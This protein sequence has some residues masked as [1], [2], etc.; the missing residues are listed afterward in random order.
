MSVSKTLKNR[1][2]VRFRQEPCDSESSAVL[3]E[4]PRLEGLSD[5]LVELDESSSR[6]IEPETVL[7]LEVPKLNYLTETSTVEPQTAKVTDPQK[8]KKFLEH[9]L[10]CESFDGQNELYDDASNLTPKSPKSV[11]NNSFISTTNFLKDN[12]RY[13]SLLNPHR[14]TVYVVRTVNVPGS[15]TIEPCSVTNSHKKPIVSATIDNSPQNNHKKH[16][17][18]KAFTVTVPS[19]KRPLARL[20][21]N[22]R[23]SL[24]EEKMNVYSSGANLYASSSIARLQEKEELQQ[25]NDRFLNYVQRVRQIGDNDQI[26][27][28]SVIKTARALEDEVTHIKSLYEKEL[29]NVRSELDRAV[30]ERNKLQMHCNKNRQAMVDLEDR[31][32]IETD[33]NKKLIEEI[34]LTQQR[35]GQ[36]EAELQKSRASAQTMTDIQK[37]QRDVDSILRENQDLKRRYEKEQIARQ[38]ADEKVHQLSK[39]VEFSEQ[40]HS[41]QSKDLHTRL[42]MATGTILELESRIRDVGKSDTNVSSVL[43]QIREASEL[44]LHKYKLES[45]GNYNRNIASLKAQMDRDTQ[46]I[47]HLTEEKSEA[48]SKIFELQGSL[49]T[50][51]AQLNLLEQQRRAAE[52]MVREEKS[53]SSEQ[54][55]AM[56]RKLKEIQDLL[57]TKMQEANVARDSSVPLKAEIDAM[58]VLLGE[59][60]K[61]LSVTASQQSTY[62]S[63]AMDQQSMLPYTP[64]AGPPPSSATLNYVP[65]TTAP[66][67][68]AAQT[69]SFQQEPNVLPLR[70]SEQNVERSRSVSPLEMVQSPQVDTTQY[71]YEVT[72][73]VNKLQRDYHPHVS[74]PVGPVARVK[75]APVSSQRAVPLVSTS[76]GQGRDYFDEMF[77]DLTRETLYTQVRPKSSPVERPPSS[78]YHDYN[79]ATSSAIGDI[80]IL[81]VQQDGKYIRL[82]NDGKQDVEFGGYLLQQNVGGHPVA[83]YRFPPRTKFSA[84]TTLTV[85]SGSND[86]LLHQPPLDFVWKE[87][88]KWGTGPECTTILCKPNG[89]A[90]AWTTAAHRFTRNAF[91]DTPNQQSTMEQEY[92]AD[93]NSVDFDKDSLTEVT[94]N[95][96]EPRQ[97]TVYLRREKQ[98]PPILT[99]QKHPHGISPG[100]DVHPTA[101]Q[102]RSFTYGNDN[103]SM[104]RQSRS[105][106]TRPDPIPGQPYAGAAGQRMGSGSLKKYPT[107][108]SVPRTNGPNITKAA[109][110]IR[111][112]PPSPFLSPLQQ[113]FQA[114]NNRPNSL[115]E[116]QTSQTPYAFMTPH[117]RFDMGLDQIKSQHNLEFQPPMPRP[118]LFSSW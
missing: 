1:K 16:S 114:F 105:Q 7:S 73:S 32:A 27:S 97:E 92:P 77:K 19:F 42:E 108:S 87:Q 55:H 101:G 60:E 74:R 95:I 83:V 5:L 38:E 46:M 23:K 35:M 64:T 15:T 69:Y 52:E 78:V 21:N 110:T 48:Q 31:I 41:Q 75:S 44:E 2:S 70:E 112:G 58:K 4:V 90:I 89:Q 117:R 91:E 104:N 28:S 61:R 12:K 82:H 33:K 86:P 36:L 94:V 14:K 45:E 13:R 54:I 106:S 50:M 115:G 93:D 51:E 10:E 88:K 68:T 8:D 30:M 111:L 43:K 17:S 20:Q 24:K 49:N 66:P 34:N 103:S 57:V 85:W 72:P 26:D 98:A 40:V 29:E 96:N 9:L 81:E 116:V 80:K 62:T 71:T 113:E 109:G 63:A 100:R 76:L 3:L 59:E 53:K 56:E 6:S 37:L 11:Q 25:L 22:S 47:N 67:V 107:M 39:S 18:R 118:P 99:A 102:A 79:I 84:N 65:T